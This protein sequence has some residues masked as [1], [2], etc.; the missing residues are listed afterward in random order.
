MSNRFEG[1]GN[2][3]KAPTL[4]N[5]PTA[6]GDRK[7]CD[8]WVYFDRPRRQEDGSFE[9]D[10]GFFMGVSLWGSRAENAM[11]HFTKGMR[12][13]VEGSARVETWEDSTDGTKSEMRISAT[14]VL[15]DPI[16]LESVVR[17]KNDKPVTEP[18]PDELEEEAVA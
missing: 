14:K 5:V 2:L 3:G 6:N 4:R 8:L 9:E 17:R 7:V 10:G 1:S 16:C 18:I 15:I 13:H 12:V 11:K